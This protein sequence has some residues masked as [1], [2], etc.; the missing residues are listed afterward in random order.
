MKGSDG[1]VGG[2]MVAAAVVDLT[3]VKEEK[4]TKQAMRKGERQRRSNSVSIMVALSWT[5]TT[6]CFWSGSFGERM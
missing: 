2:R 1:G 5:L 3:V 6:L 4:K